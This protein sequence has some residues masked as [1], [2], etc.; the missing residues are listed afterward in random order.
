MKAY[1]FSFC[2]FTNENR[3]CLCHCFEN[4]K[5]YL[6]EYQYIAIPGF[7]SDAPHS[8][9]A[10]PHKLMGFFPDMLC[11]KPWPS[12]SMFLR[13]SLVHCSSKE[14]L[15]R[16]GD[17]L[18]CFYV[19]LYIEEGKKKTPYGHDNKVKNLI[20]S[21]RVQR[22]SAAFHIACQGWASSIIP[23]GQTHPPQS[24]FTNNR[25]HGHCCRC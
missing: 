25:K 15:L 22:H 7:S 13:L 20:F 2:N 24:S 23:F 21:G 19:L 12:E 17:C 14:E 18:F 3:T 1:H 9:V 16:H 11:V 5:P 8:T 4:S 6:A 10:P